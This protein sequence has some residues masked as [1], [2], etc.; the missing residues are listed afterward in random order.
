MPYTV[1]KQGNKYIVYKKDTG[2][3][4]G[5]T[6]AN[7]ESL[8]KYLAA[9]HIHT[10]E[11]VNK[12]NTSMNRH[13][14]LTKIHENSNSEKM[15]K[16]EKK[17]FLEAVKT[18]ADHST[19]IYRKHDI[20]ETAKYLGELIEAASALTLSETEDWFDANTVGRHMK[21]LSESH[22]IFEKTA[23]EITTLQQ[24]LES[25]YEDI[26]QTLGKYYDINEMINEVTS[27]PNTP[28]SVTDYQ[29]LFVK[30]LRKFRIQSPADLVSD[31]QKRKFFNWID[32]NYVSRDEKKDNEK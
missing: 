17:A 16:T 26:G 1:R 6:D 14:K 4:V 27:R 32:N 10:N 19:S 12:N 28:S 30:A 29:K 2:K 7:K 11:S 3:R 25:A 8:R 9:L 18:F 22:K 15:S 5:A 21:H 13:D 23:D 20:K 24:R 31:K